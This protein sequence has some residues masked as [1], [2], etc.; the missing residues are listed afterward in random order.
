M[1][2]S[3]NNNL[4]SINEISAYVFVIC[5]LLSLTMFSFMYII[6]FS[7]NFRKI[8][9]LL[10]FWLLSKQDV[11]FITI[12]ATCQ[13]WA[14]CQIRK[15]AGYTCAGNAGNVYFLDVPRVSD[16]DMHHGTHVPW[17]KPVSLTSGF[18]WS[19]WRAKCFWHSQRMRN[20]QCYEFG[21]RPMIRCL[22]WIK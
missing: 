3:N 19:R 13:G 22:L 6:H 1:S 11:R 2:L 15:F 14:S 18:L 12:Y 4:L 8:L 16:P 21:K 10:F 20:P 17:C 5:M 7:I 9:P